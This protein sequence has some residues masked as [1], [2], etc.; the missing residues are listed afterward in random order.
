M[1]GSSG[2]GQACKTMYTLQH[3]L[4]RD[5]SGQIPPPFPPLGAMCYSG[6]Q[7]QHKSEER[8]FR[9]MI[10]KLRQQ[11]FDQSSSHLSAEVEYDA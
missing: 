9:V 10:V 5:F 4:A 2:T 6:L 7:L 1:G 11:K 3:H 8:S